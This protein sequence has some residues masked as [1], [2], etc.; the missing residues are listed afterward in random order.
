MASPNLSEIVTTTLNN[1]S[2]Q[3]ADNV[4][5]HNALLRRIDRNGNRRTAAGG[6]KILQELDYAENSTFQ[7]Y[8]GY[9]QLD[10]SASDVLT[11][12]EFEWKQANANVVI[13]GREQMQNADSRERIH[14]LLRSRIRNAE[15]TMRNNIATALYADGTGFSGKEIG[16]LQ[17]LVADDPSTGTVG[18]IDRSSNTF[19]RN[20]TYDFSDNSTTGSSSTIQEAMND[21]WLQ[22]IR[23]T[24][25]P[26]LI[27]AD[28]NY[29]KFYWASLQSNQRF[30]NTDEADAGFMN[31]KF[32][33]ADVIYDDQ[34][35][36]NRMYFLNTDFIFFRPHSQR[37]FVSLPDRMSVNQDAIVAP[38]VWMGN[39]TLSNASLQGVI[40]P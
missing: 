36:T 39:M 32:M 38:M 23:G 29:F 16:G 3:I 27:L 17:L 1:Y 4:T 28:T 5:N 20:Q 10:V 35:P 13:S 22:T 31:V 9:Q 24:D 8:D 18:G 19:W 7:W 34:C 25:K 21:L 30:T 40:K 14:N 15:R 2:R 12:A 6:V 33:D 37:N 11:A 26:D